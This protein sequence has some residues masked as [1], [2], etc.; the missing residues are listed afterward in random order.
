MSRAAPTWRWAVLLVPIATLP[1]WAAPGESLPGASVDSLL[2]IARSRNP[3]FAALRHEAAAAGERVI[4]A[5]ALADP[6]LRIELEN[7][8]NTGSIASPNLLPGRVG[9]AKY[10][11][12]QP[13]PFWG[14]RDLQHALAAAEADQA[15]GRVTA[16]WADLSARIKS[17]YAM[18]YQANREIA[19]TQ[20]ILDL[21]DTIE[22]TARTRYANGL[23][24]QQDV[25]RAQME[26]SVLR[27][28]LI[29]RE[30]K[31][32]HLHVLLNT[33]LHR[34][35][36]APLAE[37]TR[38]RPLPSPAKLDS[39][40][41]ERQVAAK[42]PQLL[43]GQ[44]KIDGAEKKRALIERNRYPDFAIGISPM[45]MRNRISEWGVMLEMNIPLQQES[46]RSREREAAELLDAARDQREATQSQLLGELSENLAALDA[47][48]RLEQLAE[49][50]LL[51]QAELTFKA[52][53]A[54]YENGKLDFTALLE[55]QRQIRKA[56]LDQIKA[57]T[58]AQLRLADIERLLGEDL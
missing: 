35:V 47:A 32:H 40:E 8:T 54:G 17:V 39:I 50:R 12:I 4:P 42:N 36:A 57:Q 24:S 20:E 51:P 53:L 45:Q 9:N 44:S 18:A 11:F 21:V 15:E 2:E 34:P 46:R 5:G 27:G 55:A 26:K 49:T 19:L 38:L 41:L 23:G 33:L 25:L 22:R 56:R 37:P 31:Q 48:Q 7:A 6:T 13:L 43:I 14:K 30:A 52:A 1:A 16:N 10:T 58:E 3:G 28:E 29:E